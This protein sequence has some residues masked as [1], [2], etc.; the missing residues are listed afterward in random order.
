[1]GYEILCNHVPV[2]ISNMPI[3]YIPLPLLPSSH[4]VLLSCRLVLA[5]DD[6]VFFLFVGSLAGESVSLNL[7]CLLNAEMNN[8]EFVF[9]GVLV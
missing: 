4:S 8:A 1:M 9:M 2:S 6:V 3:S 7:F 5:S